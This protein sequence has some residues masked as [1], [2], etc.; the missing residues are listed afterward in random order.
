MNYRF[1]FFLFFPTFKN[2]E[3]ARAKVKIK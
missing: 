3:M 1:L 2:F